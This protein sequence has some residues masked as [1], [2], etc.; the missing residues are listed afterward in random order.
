ML[1]ERNVSKSFTSEQREA[2]LDAQGLEAIET[3]LVSDAG[4]IREEGKYVTRPVGIGLSGAHIS[5]VMDAAELRSGRTG[6]DAKRRGARIVDVG[7]KPVV[8]A[9]VNGHTHLALAPLRGV[10][11]L[12]RRTT[13]VVTETFFR[14]EKHLSAA[15]V[16]VFSRL[17]AFECALLGIGQVWDHYYFGFEVAEA[18]REVGLGGVVAPTLQDLAGPG[19]ER[20]QE[21][22][23]STLE[24]H[25][26]EPFRKAGI[27]AALGPHASDTVSDELLGEV[28]ALARK[29]N[30][31]VHLHLAQSAEE[32]NAGRRRFESGLSEVV[33]ERL[34]GA[35]VLLA[36]GLYLTDA[37]V[38]EL[39]AL[40]SVLAYCPYSQLQFGF[41]GPL[42]AWLRAGGRF[43]V[44]TDCVAS[45][46]ALDVQRELALVGGEP[47]LRASFCAE[48]EAFAASGKSELVS[49]VERRRIALTES[50][51]I[52]A[53]ERLLDA[54]FGFHLETLTG[55]PSGISAGAFAHLLVLDPNHP[56]LYPGDDLARTLAYG[57]T[58]GAI[59][60]SVMAGSLRGASDGLART[61]L[62]TDLYRDT[63]TEARR[64][65]AELLSRVG[66]T[67]GHPAS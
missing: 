13:N 46:D 22:L 16:R 19:A 59:S 25:G 57:S 36:H 27:L 8:P 62:D 21:E 1:F 37:E 35:N 11:S 40:G 7:A 54:L 58:S 43:T 28:A 34:R 30:L 60:F 4:L 47:A 20:S 45:N 65:R 24:I 12:A 29:W 41:L 9:F 64:R 33:T 42:S 10:A 61:L 44:G 55:I 31:P 26:S 14:F 17:A 2:N 63:L 49:E 53:P 66:T 39:A 38:H 56:A 3:W 50:H 15:D 52:G 51:D 48:R 32:A 67:A 18:L 5:R 6:D 23:R